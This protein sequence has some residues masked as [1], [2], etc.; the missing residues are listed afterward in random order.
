MTK[1]LVTGLQPSGQKNLAGIPHLGNML[2]VLLGLSGLV[3]KADSAYVMV[4]DI[5]ATTQPYKPDDLRLGRM[6][7]T[8]ALMAFG[9]PDSM[10]F[11]QSQVP[12]HY[13]F[14]MLLQHLSTM[15][16]LGAMTQYRTKAL[17]GR[18]D[19]TE[20][21]N[22]P[23][24]VGLLTYPALM[25]ADVLLYRGNIV[26]A[27]DDQSQHVRFIRTL[28]ETLRK[29]FKVQFDKPDILKQETMRVMQL[30]DPTRK[31]SKSSGTALYLTDT[32]KD[33]ARKFRKAIT[34]SC[35]TVGESVRHNE[36]GTLNLVA[37]L[38]G[39]RQVPI[40][41][42]V[43]EL[44]T[45]NFSSLKEQVIAE[46]ERVI[47]PVRQKFLDISDEDIHAVLARGRD[48][49]RET[50]SATMASLKPAMGL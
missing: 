1:T 42:I 8:K 5:H 20:V 15:G 2:G 9:V 6:N 34:G 3:S 41:E 35:S 7:M 18:D 45:A 30:D 25:A 10:I 31:M 47:G 40:Q 36:E 44:E 38:A 23:V 50:A 43:N 29:R 32:P 49:A 24:P 37:I 22:I 28:A 12:E 17:Q 19:H 39:Y 14:G 21:G 11:A 26:P 48:R 4:A 27:G 13:E 16:Q 33:V 46:H